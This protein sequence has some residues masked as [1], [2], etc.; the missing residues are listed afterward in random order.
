MLIFRPKVLEGFLRTARKWQCHTFASEES[1]RASKKMKRRN[2]KKSKDKEMP[3]NCDI[4]MGQIR[5]LRSFNF[6]T[7]AQMQ[8]PKTPCGPAQEKLQRRNSVQ[9]YTEK[10]LF[11]KTREP[12]CRREVDFRWKKLAMFS[13]I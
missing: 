2:V 10:E 5:F 12:I 9:G 13:I 4:N 6:P 8:P 11:C 7:H 3:K 1:K